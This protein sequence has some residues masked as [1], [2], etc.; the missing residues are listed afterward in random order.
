M[1]VLKFG[2]SFILLTTLS[3]ERANAFGLKS[4][5]WIGERILNDINT[6]CEIELDNDT[7]KLREKTCTALREYPSDFLS[8]TLGPDIYP[9]MVVGQTTTHPGIG[10]G[11]QTD[12][13]LKY[14]LDGSS[15]PKELAFAYG[16]MV[17]A[18]SDVMAH[19][20]VNLYA[21]DEFVLFDER[22][23][24]R[25]HF[26]LEKYIDSRLPNLNIDVNSLAIPASHL[27]D[28]LI[29]NSSVNNQYLRAGTG[30]HLVSMQVVRNT[31]SE[32]DDMLEEIE[33]FATRLL[34]DFIAESVKL[35]AKH[36][37]GETKLEAL[38]ETLRVKEQLLS[39]ERSVLR[40]AKRVHDNI[41]TEISRNED[42]ITEAVNLANA[43]QRAASEARNAAERASNEVHELQAQLVRLQNRLANT[44]AELTNEVCGAARRI[45]DDLGILGGLLC[46]TVPG[47]CRVV[48]TV[49]GAWQALNNSIADTQN[50]INDASHRARVFAANASEATVVVTTELQK[51]ATKEGLRAGLE[52]SRIAA[53]IS[54][55][56]AEATLKL[57][58]DAVRVARLEVE[59]VEEE[60]EELRKKLVDT[61]S[62]KEA[63]TSLLD[64]ANI[65]TAFTK[66]W[67]KG[68]DNAAEEYL[69]TSLALSKN[70][71][72]GDSMLMSLYAD[73]LSCYGV[74]FSAVPYQAPELAC[75][76]ETEYQRIKARF[77]SFV[78]KI[79][80]PGVRELK[81]ELDR[82][83]GKVRNELEKELTKAGVELVSF[84][85][86]HATGDFVDL[87]ANPENATERKLNEIFST[88]ADA[89]GK[90]L[91]I[92]E[93]VSDLINK[94]LSL[95]DGE[96]DFEKFH[97]LNYALTL[98]KIALMPSG[99]LNKLV[100]DH[101]G[102]FW[103][104]HVEKE[105]FKEDEDYS[106]L[107]RA[108]RNIDGNHQW[109]PY[110][111][112][113]ARQNGYAPSDPSKRLFGYGKQ[114]G[115]GYGFR[116]FQD[117][118]LRMHVFLSIFPTPIGGEILRRPELQSPNYPFP[119]CRQN[120]F[121]V[122][123]DNLGNA[124]TE[125]K[126]CN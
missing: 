43:K 83:K 96:I 125:D 103:F 7:Y 8:G 75:D 10:G 102:I 20:Y 105:A 49:N 74:A 81:Q 15:S 51:K 115:N 79:L 122:T 99:S 28:S 104:F 76:V 23:V 108:V 56:S 42:E 95:K 87:L 39:A 30:L 98:S 9:D 92:F 3:V 38:R 50:R 97:A 1:Q 55:D 110:G 14:V 120:P 65:L 117:E 111:L 62:I 2:I 37:I 80:P 11:W 21:G 5:L 113:Y 31:V 109:G 26:V 36:A 85:T 73:W 84:V 12:D 89:G 67:I 114:D 40:E 48:R 52:T 57:K 118:K 88:S 29:F 82:I 13:W 116:L 66:N 4:H 64:D 70:L 6:N 17:H 61:D 24:E 32:I 22:A 60:L 86:D 47:T 59:K 101:A 54:Y 119:H 124:I 58:E 77:D 69:N 126:T 123:F 46:Q 68:I 18:A 121:P 93:K 100:R 19:T 45:C 107:F 78:D 33:D 27:R 44:P 112:P 35:S 90:Q 16:Y 91:L 106:V 25:R 34:A 71:L 72:Q 94:D 41:V 63:I 53:K